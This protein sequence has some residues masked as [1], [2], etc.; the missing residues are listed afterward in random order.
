[1]SEPQLEWREPPAAKRGR[2]SSSAIDQI[3]ADVQANPGQW[4]LVERSVNTGR[5][6]KYRKRGCEIAIRSA[7]D[8]GDLYDVYIRWPLEGPVAGAVAE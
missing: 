5:G 1:M 8:G 6:D 2:P 3:V 4:A 7:E